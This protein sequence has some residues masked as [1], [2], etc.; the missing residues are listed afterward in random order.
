MVLLDLY[1]N[2]KRIPLDELYEQAKTKANLIRA[3]I[4]S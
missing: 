4:A 3:P 1:F 2:H